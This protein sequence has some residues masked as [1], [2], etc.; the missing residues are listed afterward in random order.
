[1]RRDDGDVR[2]ERKREDDGREE[3]RRRED[4]GG[5][6]ENRRREEGGSRK[7]SGNSNSELELVGGGRRNSAEGQPP[8][9]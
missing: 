4:G 9:R 6:E 7:S 1:M 8:P 2:E 3:N 5:R